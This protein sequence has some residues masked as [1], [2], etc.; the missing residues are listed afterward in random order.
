MKAFSVL[1]L[2]SVA[3]ALYGQPTNGPV[4]WSTTVPNCSNV[5]GPVQIT[6]SAGALLGYSCYRA[7]TFVWL[8][9]GGAWNTTIRVAAPTSAP[10]GVDYTFFD[11]NGNALSFD[12]KSGSGSA[13]AS[14]SDVNFALTANQASEISLLGTTSTAPRYNTT[15]TGTAYGVFYCAN[16]ITCR[17]LLPQLV[18]SSLPAQPWSLT[19]PIAWD[20][21]EWT[22]WSAPG[23]DDGPGGVHR[24]SFVVYNQTT[25]AATYTVRVYDSAGTLAGTGTTPSIP[26]FQ[27]V[28]GNYDEGGTY[29]ALL[30]DVITTPLPS[31]VF[32]IL[33]DGGGS[34]ST[35]AVVQFTGPSATGVQVAR[36]LERI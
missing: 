5:S 31:G 36:V 29:G 26:G 7:G 20:G 17:T 28:N 15:A 3:A 2:I 4:Y 12:T 34:N 27:L 23:I 32:K 22:Q 13:T 35:V 1:G 14:G 30:S 8:A 10:V 24:V 19:I 16:Q 21:A 6:N 11:A 33:V 18:Y 9:S 25:A